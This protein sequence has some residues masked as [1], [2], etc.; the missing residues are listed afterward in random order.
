MPV[1]IK[2]RRRK[3]FEPWLKRKQISAIKLLRRF[4]ISEQRPL[5]LEIWLIR[6]NHMTSGKRS[7]R[8]GKM[9]TIDFYINSKR[10]KRLPLMSVRLKLSQQIEIYLQK[11]RRIICLIGNNLKIGL[12]LSKRMQVL[13]QDKRKLLSLLKNRKKV[14]ENQLKDPKRSRLQTSLILERRKLSNQNI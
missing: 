13:H 2:K 11:E 3:C 12:K 4:Q 1:W 10:T 14:C 5:N 6:W 8:N 9:K 7:S